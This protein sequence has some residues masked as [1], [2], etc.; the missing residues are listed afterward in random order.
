MRPLLEEWARND[1]RIKVTFL[2]EN[3]GIA[4]ATNEAE[5]LASGEYVGFLDNDDEL[6]VDCLLEVVEVIN[7]KN[8]DLVYSDEDLI[9][10][11]GSTLS[12]PSDPGSRG[13][14]CSR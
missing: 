10:N 6:T 13:T 1:S 9:G 2:T 8:G 5:K 4:R 3:G 14:T 11:D 12:V 7:N